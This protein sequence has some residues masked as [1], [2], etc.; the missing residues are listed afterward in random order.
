MSELDQTSWFPTGGHPKG[1]FGKN[2]FVDGSC[3]YLAL[4]Q[5]FARAG[6]AVVEITDEGELV[7]A[8]YGP[9][10]SRYTQTAQAGEHYA[11]LM[12]LIA[13]LAPLIATL[14]SATDCICFAWH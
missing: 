11:I 1:G 6:W 5:S 10:P 12:A 13:T 3:M 8:L 7:A 14:A 9:L 4:V 2:V